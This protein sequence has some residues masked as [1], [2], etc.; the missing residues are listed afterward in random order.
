MS[1]TQ[2]GK[3]ALEGAERW[4]SRLGKPTL[5][6]REQA[7]EGREEIVLERSSVSSHFVRPKVFDF[8]VDSSFTSRQP[9]A[10]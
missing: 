1:Q 2:D 8:S 4:E 10:C 9:S 6:G 5:L 3:G 7:L